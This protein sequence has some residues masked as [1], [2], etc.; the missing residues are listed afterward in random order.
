MWYWYISI[1]NQQNLTN[2]SLICKRFDVS[3]HTGAATATAVLKNFRES[4]DNNVA[5]V[6]GLRQI[7]TGASK[8]EAKI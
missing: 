6:Y 3:D 1:P 4:E 7:A 2:L 8:I 5:K